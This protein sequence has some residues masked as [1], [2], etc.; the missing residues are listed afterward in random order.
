MLNTQTA[1]NDNDKYKVMARNCGYCGETIYA[2]EE[3][4]LRH[5][6]DCE[7]NNL[8]NNYGESTNGQ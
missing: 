5:I 3:C 6:D 1:N 2:N 8:N 4:F 7:M